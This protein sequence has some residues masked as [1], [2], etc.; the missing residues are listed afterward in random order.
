[1]ADNVR[2]EVRSSIMS[3]IRSKNT[4]NEIKI[5]KA[6]HSAGF[7]Y[8]LHRRDLPGT[9][10][11]VLPRYRAAIFIHGCFWH[12][13]DC[14]LFKWPSTNAENWASKIKANRVRDTE[15]VRSLFASGWRVCVVW[16]CVIRG[17]QK[18]DL[19]T[20]TGLLVDWICGEQEC[21]ELRGSDNVGQT[22]R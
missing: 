1:M 7:R 13:H 2:P 5:R 10:D 17:R 3:A 6:L 8:R 19:G 11:F 15:A 18:L 22:D 20:V 12:G 14:S 9:P 21:Y 4:R 16:E